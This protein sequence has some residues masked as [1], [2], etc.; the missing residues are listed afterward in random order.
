M[1]RY[2]E[3]VKVDD[4]VEP[5][6]TMPTEEHSIEFFGRGNPMNP[7]FADAAAGK[8]LGIGGSLV[9]G[10]MKLAW[11]TQYVNDWSGVDAHVKS[12]R[13]AFRRPD[14]AGKPLVIA[15]RVVDKR[16]EDE[17]NVVELEIAMLADGQPSVRSQVIVELPSKG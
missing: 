8:R 6:E 13:V 10:L 1:T 2:F 12:V 17:K 4:E 16:Q 7:A 14:I 11:I 5:V 9:P 3:D 15:G